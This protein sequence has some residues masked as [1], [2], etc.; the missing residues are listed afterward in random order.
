[1]V[2]DELVTSAMDGDSGMV[3]VE[4]EA[5]DVDGRGDLV[6]IVV[7]PEELM[8][9]ARYPSLEEVANGEGSSEVLCPIFLLPDSLS[10]RLRAP[11]NSLNSN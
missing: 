8:V 11:C 2:T 5:P 6:T 3:A 7:L 4:V 9:T 10:C 1:M